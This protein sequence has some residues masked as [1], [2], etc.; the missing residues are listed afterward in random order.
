MN[1]ETQNRLEALK[2]QRD[3]IKADTAAKI[4]E[5]KEQEKRKAAALRAAIRRAAAE[6]TKRRKKHEDHCKIIVGVAAIFFAQNDAQFRSGLERN[7]AEFYGTAPQKLA[8]AREALG[9][10]VRKP[11]SDADRDSSASAGAEKAKG[12]RA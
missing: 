3:Q 9:F 7:L 5:L 2:A 1:A 12:A 10:T 11:A 8:E 4:A 6:E